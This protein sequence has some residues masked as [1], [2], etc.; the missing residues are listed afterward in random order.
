MRA[1]VE[2][3]LADGEAILVEV[4]TLDEGIVRAGRSGEKIAIADKS[5]PDALEQLRPMAQAVVGKFRDL[6]ERPDAITVEFGISWTAK[7]TMVIAHT[8][9]EANLKVVLQWNRQ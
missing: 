9:A 4:E 3:P 5:F 8:G 2:V 7:A 1:L 6:A